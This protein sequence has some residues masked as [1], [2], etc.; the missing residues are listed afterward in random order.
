MSLK[1][2]LA[3]KYDGYN[4]WFSTRNCTLGIT[5]DCLDS[6]PPKNPEYYS[7]NIDTLSSGN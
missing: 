4:K 7:D 2:I 1:Y 3:V 6:K 5:R